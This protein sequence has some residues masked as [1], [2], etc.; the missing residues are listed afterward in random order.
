MGLIDL[1]SI[2]EHLSFSC[3]CKV[4]TPQQ[5]QLYIKRKNTWPASKVSCDNWLRKITTSSS[6]FFLWWVSSSSI[7]YSF[8]ISALPPAYYTMTICY[9]SQFLYYR[10]W[11]E[12]NNAGKKNYCTSGFLKRCSWFLRFSI[13]SWAAFL[14]WISLWS[15][16]FSSETSSLAPCIRTGSQNIYLT[17]VN[18]Q[19]DIHE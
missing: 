7:L 17:E 1:I 8:K 12:L 18:K 14:E 6:S 11:K 19:V 13:S 4:K 10:K 2:V 5:H 9:I 16:F 3:E 15:N